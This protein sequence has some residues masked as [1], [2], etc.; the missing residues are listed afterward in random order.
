MQQTVR[1]L[2]D[3][4]ERYGSEHKYHDLRSPAEAIKLLCINEPKFAKELAQAHEHGIGYTVVQADEF[5][6][7]DDLH[8]P[9]GSNDL[10]LTPVI[11]GSGGGGTTTILAGVGLIAAAIIFAPA[12]AGFLGVGLG[13]GATTTATFSLAAGAYVA[14][15][16][17]VLSAGLSVALG[18][19]G[20]SLVLTGVSQMLSPQPTVPSIGGGSRTSPGENTNATGP[21][22]VSRATSG[23]QSYAFSG[24]ANT[25]GVGATVP[26]VYG[27]LLIGSHLISSK[28]EVTSESDPTGAYFSPP[29]R[30]SITVNGEKPS[31]E[32]EVLNGLRTRRWF[33][34]QTKFRNRQSNNGRFIQ[35]VRSDTLNFNVGEID[36]VSSVIDFDADDRKS[37]NLQIFFEIDNGLSRVIGSQL[38]PAFV[39]YEITLKKSNYDGESPVFG[40]VRATVQGLLRKTDNYKWCHAIDVGHSGV[41]DNDTVVDTRVQVIDTDADNKGGRIRIRAIGYKNFRRNS[42]NFTENLV[43]DS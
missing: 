21:Q 27:K 32:F 29:G 7:Y 24:P 35:R 43:V 3:L 20:T 41:E 38:V 14:T 16:A 39:T 36:R 30:D 6:G 19:I 1:L 15:T 2:G 25:V 12:G 34:H 31:F 4:G 42:E 26:L 18:A 10:V 5:L 22:G 33:Y 40:R 17:S 8:L 11:A 9:L 23:Q 28:V 37:E 13:V